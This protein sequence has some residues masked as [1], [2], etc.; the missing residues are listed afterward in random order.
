M[1]IYRSWNVAFLKNPRRK[2]LEMDES[3]SSKGFVY[4]IAHKKRTDAKRML[5]SRRRTRLEK[6]VSKTR[7][8][9]RREKE[10]KDSTKP[11]RIEWTRR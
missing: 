8:I 11:R 5:A 9:A 3:C 6:Y 1:K 2:F 7:F 10:K 4:L